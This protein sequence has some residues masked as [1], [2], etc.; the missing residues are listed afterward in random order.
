M[1]VGEDESGERE[2]GRGGEEMN[3]E[4]EKWRILGFG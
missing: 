4:T 1:R 2:K 3:R